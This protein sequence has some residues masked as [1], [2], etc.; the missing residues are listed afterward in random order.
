MSSPKITTGAKP[1][2]EKDKEHFFVYFDLQVTKKIREI[3]L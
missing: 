1:N 2:H 3:I